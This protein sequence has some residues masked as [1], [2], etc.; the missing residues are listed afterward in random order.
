LVLGLCRGRARAGLPTGRVRAR[1]LASAPH[2]ALLAAVLDTAEVLGSHAEAT[3]FSNTK[4][5]K[6]LGFWLLASALAGALT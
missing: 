1:D 5:A 3:G 4:L 6:L 2:A